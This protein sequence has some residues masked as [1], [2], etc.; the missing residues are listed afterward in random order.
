MEVV[1]DPDSDGM[2]IFTMIGVSSG[3]DAMELA[4][5]SA[6]EI[7]SRGVSVIVVEFVGSSGARG[8]HK[9]SNLLEHLG[10]MDGAALRGY[11][12]RGGARFGMMRFGCEDDVDGILGVI[13]TAYDMSIVVLG[14]EGAVASV[15]SLGEFSGRAS[16]ALPC[17]YVLKGLNPD[18]IARAG[19]RI[20]RLM[21]DEVIPDP[22]AFAL[23]PYSVGLAS[24]LSRRWKIP[25]WGDACDGRSLSDRVLARS[26]RVLRRGFAPSADSATPDTRQTPA[27][28]VK[29]ILAELRDDEDY[30]F[31]ERSMLGR[32]R[33]D[34][35]GE[36]RGQVERIARRIANRLAE[37]G[38]LESGVDGIISRVIDE[39]CGLGPLEPYVC[40]PGVTE[41]MACGSRDIYIERG[42]RI[43]KSG[44]RF[45]DD[46]HLMSIIDRILLPIGRRVDELCPFADARLA[47]GSRVHAIIPPLAVDGPQL[48]I[49]RFSSALSSIDEAVDNGTVPRE[50]ARFLASSVRSRASM[51]I[52]GGTGS[53]KTTLLNILAAEMDP[54][55]RIITIEDAAEL[56]LSLPHVVRLESR[57]PN[58]E[59]AGGIAIRDLVRNALRMRPDRIVVGEC[60]G[61]EALDMLQAMNTGHEG[62]LTT[63]HANSSRDAIARIET[64]VMM[65]D[66]D[67][68]LKAV[69]EQIARGV[70]LV[71]QVSRM[72]DGSRKVVEIAEVTGMEG[73]VICLQTIAEMDGG[74]MLS[75]TGLAPNFE[76][77][78]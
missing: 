10:V 1:R 68:P 28:D 24:E 20:R 5:R 2:N 46:E 40:D 50:A 27:P 58:S 53:G 13:S 4:V 42:G 12:A 36:M 77:N 70:D 3:D 6:S 14:M 55:E 64:M 15:L 51:I 31:V 63:I 41:I 69:R 61:A 9:E 72:K 19:R 57:P 76:S 60:R 26:L 74:G 33:S 21:D 73:E 17:L 35:S 38:V 32:S 7:S 11:L 39:A 16:K 56:R 44:A 49:R 23:S 18:D 54:R 37:E 45:E 52:S 59:G 62:S 25:S 67:L 22:M 66:V 8:V 75:M 78:R 71:V 30:K 29:R 47:D 34:E 48:T 43:E 65:A